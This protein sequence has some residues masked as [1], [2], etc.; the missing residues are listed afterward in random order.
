MDPSMTL[1]YWRAA[2]WDILADKAR[3]DVQEAWKMYLSPLL[4]SEIIEHNQVSN[5]QPLTN[6]DEDVNLHSM[7]R[8]KI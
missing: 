5:D 1:Q 2:V 4:C 7:A 6:L 3:E 8:R